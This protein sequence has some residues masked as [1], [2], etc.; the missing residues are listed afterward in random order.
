M[1]AKYDLPIMFYNVVVCQLLLIIFLNN[2]PS[3]SII[4]LPLN[5]ALASHCKIIIFWVSIFRLSDMYSYDILSC[6][7]YQQDLDGV[8]RN[9]LVEV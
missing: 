2:C 1:I 4:V 9:G 5:L 8:Q 3:Y 7:R 6:Y